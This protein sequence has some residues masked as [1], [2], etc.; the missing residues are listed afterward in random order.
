MKAQMKYAGPRGSKS[1]SGHRGRGFTLIELMVALSVGLFFSVVVFMLVRDVSRYFQRE[2][3]LAD[4]TMSAIVGFERLKADISRAGFLASPLLLKD[5]KRC[6]KPPGMLNAQGWPNYLPLAQ[7]GALYIT[8]GGGGA[9]LS[10]P[11]QAFLTSNGLNPDRIRFYGNYQTAEQFPV[12]SISGGGGAT[13]AIQLR[14]QSGALRRLGYNPA[15]PDLA[16]LNNAFPVGRALRVVSPQGEEQYSIIVSV[17]PDGPGN[18]VVT[19]DHANL[20]LR[21][22]D[23]EPTCGI[24]DGGAGYQV[25]V[26]NIIEYGLDDNLVATDPNYQDLRLGSAGEPWPR[27]DLVREEL[28]PRTGAVIPNTSELIAEYAVDLRFGITALTDLVGGAMTTFE[29]GNAA[30][31]AYVTQPA[32]VALNQGPHF[33]RGLRAQLSVR[34]RA[35]DREANIPGG[36]LPATGLY[37]V[38]LGAGQFAR[39]RTLST[40]IATRN[41]RGARWP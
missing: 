20:S 32:S 2:T 38:Q 19:V 1:R 17:V 10:G 26:V 18:P 21:Y 27:V 39:V 40:T 41:T 15:A 13:V 4:A 28:N 6:P 3:R 33:I 25:N 9:T 7:M 16:L 37:R 30:M 23:T 35:P 24:R 12:E 8:R 11:G 22:K 36:L 14:G 29:P 5:P 31:D 34:A